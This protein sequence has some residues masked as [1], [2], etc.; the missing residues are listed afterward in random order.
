M[1]NSPRSST[2]QKVLAALGSLVLAAT[3]GIVGA[4]AGRVGGEQSSQR[5][6]I[7]FLSLRFN[8]VDNDMQYEQA[9]AM[10][11]EESLLL[12][13]QVLNLEGQVLAL[14]GEVSRVQD[15]A[16]QAQAEITT[17]D[18]TR[19]QQAQDH[20]NN[21]NY[22]AAIQLLTV[23]TPEQSEARI[24]LDQEITAFELQVT[25]QVAILL[26]ERQHDE[27]HTLV[28]DAIRLLPS[29]TALQALQDEIESRR[30][31]TGP[32]VT[33]AAPYGGSNSRIEE[34]VNMGGISYRNV[35]LYYSNRNSIR[36][37]A[38]SYHNLEARFQLLAGYVG[39]VDGTA[40][41][42]VTLII[43]GDGEILYEREVRARALPVP[44]SVPVE[45]VR[46]LRIEIGT[47]RQGAQYALALTFE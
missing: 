35:M 19:M 25:G 7:E 28:S 21:G 5:D 39:H 11:Y 32:L 13:E 9:L 26:T 15:E 42:N 2:R 43:R 23:I 40:A 4:I 27:A 20:V 16:A 10:I 29:S 36:V 38:F 14:K 24:L 33:Q 30:T 3:T 6:T 34:R 22:Q 1:S 44:I 47:F 18:E 37:T 41:Y 31:R 12:Q 17:R 46:E 8:S 45:G